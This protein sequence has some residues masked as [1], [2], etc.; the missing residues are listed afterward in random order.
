MDYEIQPNGSLTTI[1]VFA[2]IA[3]FVLLIA[4]INF[5]NLSTARA[6]KRAKEVGMRKTLGGQR[7]QLVGQFLFESILLCLLSVLIAVVV[8]ALALPFFN[9]FAEKNMEITVL[10]EPFYLALLTLLPLECWFYFRNLSCVCIVFLPTH[11]C[12]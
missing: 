11:H 7:F 1:Y 3:I 10:L 8:V 2:S 4:C 6:A 5:I 12:P 9:V